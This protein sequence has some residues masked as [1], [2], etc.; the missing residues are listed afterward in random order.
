MLGHNGDTYLLTFPRDSKDTLQRAR[1]QIVSLHPEQGD[2]TLYRF[3]SLTLRA[4]DKLCFGS[5]NNSFRPD[6]KTEL[7]SRKPEF[8]QLGKLMEKFDFAGNDAKL[9]EFYQAVL[10]LTYSKRNIVIDSYP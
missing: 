6:M 7:Q 8:F 9:L 5:E 1:D 10:G 3:E 4:L 2:W